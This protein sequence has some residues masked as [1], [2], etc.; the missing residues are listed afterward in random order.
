MWEN[1]YPQ[2][3]L[4]PPLCSKPRHVSKLPGNLVSHIVFIIMFEWLLHGYV[5]CKVS[6][7]MTNNAST[8]PTTAL[9]QSSEAHNYVV[10]KSCELS[11]STLHVNDTLN[12]IRDDAQSGNI[13]CRQ[14]NGWPTKSGRSDPYVPAQTIFT[15]YKKIIFQQMHLHLTVVRRLMLKMMDGV[16]TIMTYI[17]KS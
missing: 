15:G 1:H 9:E 4:A 7:N 3:S 2:S 6:Q 5:C 10:L 11:T 13:V 8:Q 14:T 17:L 12:C 16:R